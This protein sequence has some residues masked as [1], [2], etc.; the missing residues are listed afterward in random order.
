MI[1]LRTLRTHV[2]H[3]KED[4]SCLPG[5]FVLAGVAGSTLSLLVITI[6][7]VLR[8]GYSAI[9][10]A[11]SDMGERP[12]GWLLNKDLIVT[13]LLILLFAV[14]LH[15]AMRTGLGRRTVNVVTA[16]F[17]LAGAGIASDG[18]FTEYKA[19]AL[20]LLGFYSAFTALTLVF[21]LVGVHL[22]RLRDDRRGC[23]RRYGWYSLV[24]GIVVLLLVI[25]YV[26]LPAYATDY[27]GLLE[28]LI[29][30]TSFGWQFVTACK[31]LRPR[32]RTGNSVRHPMPM[33]TT[34]RVPRWR[35]LQPVQILGRSDWVATQCALQ[36]VRARRHRWHDEHAIATVTTD[37]D[38]DHLD[39]T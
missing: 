20:H 31:L 27:Q 8:P 19:Y 37:R 11:I 36:S 38:L 21:F 2:E 25:V 39:T 12:Y 9:A 23:W 4:Q 5:P 30:L 35:A 28:R 18:V 34:L 33:P 10:D 3:A 16:L 13:G 24:T 22:L 15:G 17:M 6:D 7:G 1:Q 26:A 32:E 29:V 14:G